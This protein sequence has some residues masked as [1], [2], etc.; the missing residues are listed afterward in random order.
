MTE[1]EN[2]PGIRIPPPFFYLTGFLFAYVINRFYPIP[3][4]GHPLSVV[5]AMISLLPSTILGLW[6]LFEFWHANTNLRPDK[7]SSF[8]VVIGPYRITRN[9]MYL[10]LTLLYI[11]LGFLLSVAWAFIFLPVIIFIMNGY[12]IR[13]EELYLETRFGEQY[14]V[15]KNQVRRWL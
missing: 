5:L 8:L 11:G 3:I 4:F 9:P 14:R 15:Y 7:P 10:S 12:V 1:S 13:R 2:S 6:S